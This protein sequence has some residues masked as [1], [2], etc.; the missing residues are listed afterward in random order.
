MRKPNSVTCN[1]ECA[2]HALYRYKAHFWLCHGP[3]NSDCTGVVVL[4]VP[5][6]LDPLNCG[7]GSA[8]GLKTSGAQGT[9]GSAGSFEHRN[10]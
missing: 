8:R 4:M 6:G 1:E 9:P 5:D 10:S 2:D 7:G 3:A